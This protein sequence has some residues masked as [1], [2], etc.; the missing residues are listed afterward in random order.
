L[1]VS[2]ATLA[3]G[4]A[5]S[6]TFAI[7]PAASA[8]HYH[9]VHKLHRVT[10]KSQGAQGK[11]A[12]KDGGKVVAVVL[13]PLASF[14]SGD[15]DRDARVQE[16]L[17][18]RGVSF[19]VFKGH[20]QLPEP[21]RGQPVELEMKGELTLHGV[22]RPM[23]IAVSLELGPGGVAHVRGRFEVSLEAHEIERPSLLFVKIEDTCTIDVDLV[24][25]DERP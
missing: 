16:I 12:I 9:I 1:N 15:F 2:R 20:T 18:S 7:D 23:T 19:V 4:P 13:V 5:S 17:G 3:E 6:T 14:R 24:L 21:E 10:G 25:R 8:I 11:V 22:R